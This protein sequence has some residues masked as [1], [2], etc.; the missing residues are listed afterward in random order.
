MSRKKDS[1]LVEGLPISD[2]VKLLLI[3][4]LFVA[5]VTNHIMIHFDS[6]LEYG[7]R[8]IVSITLIL[9]IISLSFG[10]IL[11]E[12]IVIGV[13]VL[14]IA[15]NLWDFVVSDISDFRKTMLIGSI[16]LLMLSISFG[17][18]SFSNLGQ[19]IKSQ[20]GASKKR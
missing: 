14:A 15:S 5:L 9:L 13:L 12:T 18:I 3:A 11:A 8:S 16:I 19:V 2:K 7:N 6:T 20:L 10:N 17:K 4:T 1:L